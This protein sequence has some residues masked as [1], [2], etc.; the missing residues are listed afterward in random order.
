MSSSSGEEIPAE[1]VMQ[2]IREQQIVR[3]FDFWTV[4]NGPQRGA[5]ILRFLGS[6]V[7]RLVGIEPDQARVGDIA[8][9]NLWEMASPQGL[10][11]LFWGREYEDITDWAERLTMAAE[12]VSAGA[13]KSGTATC[14]KDSPANQGGE[15]ESDQDQRVIE[16]EENRLSVRES[17]RDVLGPVLLQQH[18]PNRDSVIPMILQTAQARTDE[19]DHKTNEG[20]PVGL[21]VE[22]EDFG[23]EIRD[24]TGAHPDAPEEGAELLCHITGKETEWMGVRRKDGRF[25]QHNACCFGINHQKNVHS[26]QL[27][28]LG[29]ESEEELS[30][31]SVPGE[32]IVP[33]HD[34]PVQHEEEQV[35]LKRRRPQY[36]D[37]RQ[38]LELMQSRQRSKTLYIFRECTAGLVS[39][40]VVVVEKQSQK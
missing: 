14:L 16:G 21:A 10:D 33:V 38:Q 20:N 34:E 36:Y 26:H 2:E 3:R 6:G 29:V 15:V 9:E 24:I 13:I 22:D 19:P 31:E 25:V 35:V 23:E 40:I 17:A 39:M 32:E 37:R 12:R 1:Q 11:D 5:M 7:I 18:K 4:Q 30:E 28:M 27:F 8:V